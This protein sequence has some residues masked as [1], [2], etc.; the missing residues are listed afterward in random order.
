MDRFRSRR[1]N[2]LTLL[3]LL[4]VI[5]IIAVLLGLLL[6]A[7]QKVRAA[8]ARTQSCNNLSQIT[9]ASH[10]Y[11]QDFGLL[12]DGVTA[13]GGSPSTFAFS[14]VFVKCL[15]Y[16]EQDN[17]YGNALEDGL[18]ALTVAIPIYISPAD[19]SAVSHLGLTS[20]VGNA[21]IF[22]VAGCSLTSSI[23]DGT[24]NTILFTERYMACGEPPF[25]NAWAI[26]ASG[27]VVNGQSRTLAA[28]LSVNDLPQLGPRQSQCL[29]G[30]AQGADAS[31]ILTAMADGS[32][33]TVSR[34]AA[35]SSSTGSGTNWQA[36][37]TPND[38]E[39]LGSDW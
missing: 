21:Q 25:F 30:Y 35:A 38:G 32:V 29:A 6:P 39:V 1:A 15:P 36:A 14:S 4:V 3:E 27:L 22:G 20:Y 31:F 16:V 37:L 23:P 17:L 18:L 7:V 26:N 12:P 24:S 10:H 11:Q 2:A 13:L 33:R 28:L 9:L 34:T 19:S 8:A 5:A